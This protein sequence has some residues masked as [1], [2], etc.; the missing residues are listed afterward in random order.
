MHRS[1]VIYIETTGADVPVY[2]LKV[3]FGANGVD[4][5]EDISYSD[6]GRE[7]PRVDLDAPALPLASWTHLALTMD[8][9]NF[10]LEYDG[11]VALAAAFGGFVPASEIDFTLGAIGYATSTI[12]VVFDNVVC[13][14][15]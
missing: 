14:V 1:D 13:N 2:G 8:F 4:V 15:E 11:Q 9:Q 6:G 10:R 12:D 5:R 7:S 3:A